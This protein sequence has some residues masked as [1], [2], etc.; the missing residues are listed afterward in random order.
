MICILKIGQRKMVEIDDKNGSDRGETERRDE[1]IYNSIT[2]RFRLERERSYSLDGKASSIINLVGIIIGIEAGLASILLK[3]ISRTSDYYIYVCAIFFMGIVF[4]A[5]SI[6]SALKSYYV[7]IWH[8]VPDPKYL[9]EE[10][11]KKDRSKIDTLRI[12]SNEIADSIEYNEKINNEKARFIGYAL[13]FLV[14]GI[15]INV[16]FI[17]ILLV[18]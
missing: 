1:L 7:K 15:I 3:D 12:M 18:I 10:Y 4:L 2:N 9:I 8:V 16:F 17:C 5:C 11:A 6:L 14:A 13:I